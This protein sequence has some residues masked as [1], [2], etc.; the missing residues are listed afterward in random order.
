MHDFL[1]PRWMCGFSDRRWR[2]V[3]FLDLVLYCTSLAMD[4]FDR[5]GYQNGR[6]FHIHKHRVDA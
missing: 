4:F 5:V 6:L 2:K 1:G 3:I